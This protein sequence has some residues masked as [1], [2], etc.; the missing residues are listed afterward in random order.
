MK[1]STNSPRL[2]ELVMLILC[3]QA[4]DSVAK[5]LEIALPGCQDLCG[6]VSIAYPFG[7]GS[8]C[9]YD[10]WYE[11]FCNTSFDPPRPILRRLNVH[12][13]LIVATQNQVFVQM[14]PQTI[15]KPDAAVEST[16]ESVSGVNLT[17]TPFSFSRLNSF[18]V[19]GCAASV[20]LMD[21]NKEIL[22]GCASLCP[23]N[24]HDTKAKKDCTVGVGCCQ[25]SLVSSLDSYR[26]GFTDETKV[27]TNTCMTA[28]LASTGLSNEDN[29]ST[30]LNWKIERLPFHS[31]QYHIP[32]CSSSNGHRQVTCQCINLI[33]AISNPYLPNGCSTDETKVATN[34]CMTAG[35]AS[36]GLSNEDNSSTALN[37]KI[38]R[39]P[40]HSSQYHIPSCSSSN[41]HRQVTCQCINLIDGF[42]N[43]Y[44]PKACCID[45]IDGI[46]NPYLPNGCCINLTDGISNPYLANGCCI[47]V[48]DDI[49]NPYLPNGCTVPGG[50]EG[51]EGQ[52]I[53]DFNGHQGYR[54]RKTLRSNAIV[55]GP[56]AGI[57]T[58]I[59]V[60]GCYWLYK[61]VKRYKQIQRKARNFK[62]NGGLLLQQELSSDDGV[63]NKLRIF[64]MNELEK[65][66]DDFNENRIVGEG[67]QGTVYKGM[68]MEGQ[69][70]A[71]KKSKQ[72]DKSQLEQ[73]ANE[74]VILSGINHRN[75]VEVLGCCLETDDPML[76]YE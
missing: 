68:L 46:G 17:E 23:R 70:V 27:A 39:L 34:T 31:S 8:G 56:S 9:F 2:A 52:C 71:V 67:G 64:T 51:C 55:T 30:A 1:G 48:I 22:A 29:S 74:M 15:C 53:R 75:V 59:L 25:S 76:V 6:K 35:L 54:C 40:F 16:T 61:V 73:F 65:A 37:W 36:T 42:N 33:D 7:I 20:V 4:F 12:V 58:I 62:R 69:I 72:V 43:P 63:V 13:I 24:G 50:C 66:T 3:L 19:E 11:V 47:N 26:V 60:L 28:G 21:S 45:L 5:A 57:G 32:S 49:S 14:Q 41:G 38:E 18:V 44:L 10:S